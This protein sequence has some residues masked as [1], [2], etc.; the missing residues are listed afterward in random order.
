MVLQFYHL[1]FL[2]SVLLMDPPYFQR[3]YQPRRRPLVRVLTDNGSNFCSNL[4]FDGVAISSFNPFTDPPYNRWSS[5]C[6]FQQI[7][8]GSTDRVADALSDH[9][10][11]KF[12]DDDSYCCSN[13][14]S[15]RFPISLPNLFTEKSFH[16]WSYSWTYH[17]PDSSSE[18]ISNENSDY[19]SNAPADSAPNYSCH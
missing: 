17:I 6:W 4:R 1:V 15:N 9:S 5:Y 19:S 14:R 12:T 3:L 8:N 11:H 13:L 10:S 7:S 18:R 2:P 16:R